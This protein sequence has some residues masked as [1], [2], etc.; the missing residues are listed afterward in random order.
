MGLWCIKESARRPHESSISSLVTIS[1]SDSSDVVAAVH[2][3]TRLIAQDVGRVLEAE[4][5]EPDRDLKKETALDWERE[6]SIYRPDERRARRYCAP[7]SLEQT[8]ARGYQNWMSANRL[9][10]TLISACAASENG[11]TK[12]SRPTQVQIS[13]SDHLP[14]TT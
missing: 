9:A 6:N 3:H 4:H 14:K 2:D 8:N 1:G 10:R 5:M 11:S 12:I 7:E 13:I